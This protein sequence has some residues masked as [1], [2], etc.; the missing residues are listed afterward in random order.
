MK[1][2]LTTALAAMALVSTGA[3]AAPEV[4]VRPQLHETASRMMKASA[5]EASK[6]LE[7]FEG[8]SILNLPDGRFWFYSYSKESEYIEVSEFFTDEIVRRF[9]FTIY[10][11]NLNKVATIADEVEYK[12]DEVRLVA[13]EPVTT[14]SKKF[15]HIDDSYEMAISFAY[16]TP[17]Y[18]NNNYTRVY[19]LNGTTDENGDSPVVYEMEGMLIGDMV[20]CATEEW[21]EDYF[22]TFVKDV[23]LPEN[24][25]YENY[26]IQLDTYSKATYG[27]EPSLVN[28]YTV[29]SS[30]MPGDQENTPYMMSWTE[31]KRAF[32]FFSQYEKRFFDN[33]TGSDETDLLSPDNHL[34]A[35]IYSIGR[36]ESSMK[37]EKSV[38]VPM[39]QQSGDYLAIFYSIGNLGYRSDIIHDGDKWQFVLAKQY[40]TPESEDTLNS[41]FLIDDQSNVINPIFEFS[42]SATKFDSLRGES[43]QYLFSNID[44]NA[45]YLYHIVNFPSG[46]LVCTF[47]ALYNGENTLQIPA[48][49]VKEN[50]NIYYVFHAALPDVD[51]QGNAI[52]MVVWVNEAGEIDHIDSINLGQGL[53]LASP[54]ISTEALSPY[55]V[56]T[57]SKR[58]YI[59]M[60]KKPTEDNT[61]I[62]NYLVIVNTDNEVIFELGPRGNEELFNVVYVNNIGHK[63]LQA[64]YQDQ[65]TD[66][67]SCDF[68]SLPLERFQGGSGTESDPYL[69]AS[70]ADLDEMR[71]DPTAF[72]RVVSN[73]DASGYD[74]TPIESDFTGTLDGDNHRIDN[75]TLVAD[76]YNSGI[77]SRILGGTVK[78]LVLNNID[79]YVTGDLGAAGVLAGNINQTTVS[80]VHICGLD[81]NGD[82]VPFGGIAG[83]AYLN[84][85][86]EGSSVTDASI[87]LPGAQ[88]VGGLVGSMRTGTSIKSS[89][90]EGSV[91]AGSEVGGIA[92]NTV[93]GDETI[94]NCHVDADLTANSTVG[95]IIGS[96]SR[97]FIS[98]CYVEG[99]I[100]T[101]GN[102]G[103][104]F[105]FGPCA[106]GVVGN[107]EPNY[108]EDDGI[109]INSNVVSLSA[110][111]GAESSV[112]EQYPGQQATLHRIVGR[113][114]ANY[115]ADV[116]YD[117]EGNVMEDKSGQ[118]DPG[119]A[120]NYFVVESKSGNAAYEDA[121]SVEG[122]E[123]AAADFKQA[124]LTGLGFSF[125]EV[126]DSPWIFD[127]EDNLALFFEGIDNSG[128]ETIAPVQS[129]LRYVGGKLIADNCIIEVYSIAGVKMAAGNDVL[130][131]DNLEN[132]I[133]VAVAVDEKGNR[134]VVK[135]RK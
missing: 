25:L 63:Q 94:S 127:E 27:E 107:L 110:L 29:I 15:F 46:E 118:K 65:R 130:S 19:S 126:I 11:E 14:L 67:Y 62:K 83:F 38:K 23:T 80:N 88:G 53:V 111:E 55:Y 49:R 1:K 84:S 50:G 105:D 7:G 24:G 52:D 129:T 18:I 71:N 117:D 123:L 3:S 87:N 33:P 68:Y 134:S 124:T 40:Y 122:A 30:H 51:R 135:F 92:G 70:I 17:R 59:Y 58:E 119:L 89:A 73:F 12:E 76:Q 112:A 79:V 31:G 69:I 106:G 44:E 78:N 41:Y 102:I 2:H 42:E 9:E 114:L 109:R 85:V 86:I 20:N 77:F 128:V 56:N 4:N 48:A 35:D 60:I 6:S 116:E 32:F 104:R 28:S 115:K 47:P 21:S 8:L 26:G 132:G 54:T 5:P 98:N 13:L 81:V 74:F 72:Y 103:S 22:V 43:D 64:I 120:Y 39:E 99:K 97:S 133:Y 96:S 101:L 34:L 131:I 93:T 66:L 57:D 91:I 61:S 95:G 36:G 90:F 82:P 10:D 37:L 75:L 45:E 113:S 16:N 100:K 108:L 121:S 125:G